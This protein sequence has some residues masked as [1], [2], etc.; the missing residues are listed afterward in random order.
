MGGLSDAREDFALE[1]DMVAAFA[2]ALGGRAGEAWTLYHETAGFDVLAVHRDGYQVGIEAK[3]SMNVEVVVQALPG[4]HSVDTGPDYRAV[5]VPYRKA[6]KPSG[7]RALLPHLGLNVLSVYN[8]YPGAAE[9]RWMLSGYMPDEASMYHHQQEWWNWNPSQ[10][11]QVPD[12]IPDVCGGDKAPLALTPWKVQAIKLCV[13]LDRRGHV[14]RKDMQNLGLSP[15]RW[16]ERTFGYLVPDGG[17]RYSRCDRTPDFRAQH[18]RNY[19]E[20][21]A[22]YDKWFKPTPADWA[23]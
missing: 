3:L 7:L 23:P 9:P 20:I 10:R 16:T 4:H 6:F 17:G 13:L 19:A 1:K 12:Y 8:S 11:C 15:S 22:D 14:S 18:P 5:L 21:E 2:A